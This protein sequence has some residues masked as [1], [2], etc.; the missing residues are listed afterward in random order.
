MYNHLLDI[1][2]CVADEGSINRASKKLFISPV[3]IYKEINKLEKQ[4]SVTLF[5]RDSRGCHLTNEERKFIK[6]F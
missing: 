1:F 6:A 2:K 3:S 5:I 4:L